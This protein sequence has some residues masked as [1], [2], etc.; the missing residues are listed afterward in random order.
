MY[1]LR[2]SSKSNSRV[3]IEGLYEE[4]QEVMIA[5]STYVLGLIFKIM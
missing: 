1:I 3:E 2:L 5:A 4:I